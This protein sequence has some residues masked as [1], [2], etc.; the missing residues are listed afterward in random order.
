RDTPA[1]SAEPRGRD[2]VDVWRA[3]AALLPAGAVVDVAAAGGQ[4]ITAELVGVDDAG[5][6][7]R[8]KTRMVE[9]TRT[10]PFD[11]MELLR[12]HTGPSSSERAGAIAAGIGTGAGVFFGVLI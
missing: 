10:I 7:V 6:L 9:S 5:V 1:A 12:L 4:R 2:S 3:Y 8:P 11:R